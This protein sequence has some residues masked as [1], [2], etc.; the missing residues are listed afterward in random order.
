MEDIYKWTEEVRVK[1]AL[2]SLPLEEVK[3]CQGV[4]RE[5]EVMFEGLDTTFWV[6]AQDVEGKGLAVSAAL[7][8]GV[9]LGCLGG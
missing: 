5:K 3:E 8:V 7:K 9:C 2:R 1:L 4:L 6:L